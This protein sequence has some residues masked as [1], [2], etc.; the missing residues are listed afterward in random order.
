MRVLREMEGGVVYAARGPEGFA[1][2]AHEGMLNELVGED[3]LASVS[4][5]VFA[6][7][8]ERDAYARRRG[9]E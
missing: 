6:T 8:G 2:I 7:E 4:I 9:W 3:D 5:R 1:V